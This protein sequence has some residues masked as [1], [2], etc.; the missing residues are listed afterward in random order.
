VKRK[1]FKLRRVTSYVRSFD[2][3]GDVKWLLLRLSCGHQIPFAKPTAAE[4]HNLE[5][6]VVR[7]SEGEC[8]ER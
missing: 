7:C 5:R 4:S 1:T 6:K 8:G 2:H 3:K